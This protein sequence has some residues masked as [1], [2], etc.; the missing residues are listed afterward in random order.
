MEN[1]EAIHKLMKTSYNWEG[2]S[3]F[4]WKY[5]TPLRML[6]K[7]MPGT[8]YESSRLP[9]L[10]CFSSSDMAKLF[11]DL[12]QKKGKSQCTYWNAQLNNR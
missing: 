2:P 4:G 12:C 6:I 10:N 5:D 1:K 9:E 3:I 8:H 7:N 11:L